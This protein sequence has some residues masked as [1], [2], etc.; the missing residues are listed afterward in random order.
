M[1]L[2]LLFITRRSIMSVISHCVRRNSREWTCNL[3]ILSLF[4]HRREQKIV[5]LVINY[6]CVS[7]IKC[8]K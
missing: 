8:F 3:K 4:G 6:K 7:S 1:T 2:V 5:F